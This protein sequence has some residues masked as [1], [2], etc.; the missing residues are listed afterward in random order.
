MSGLP[1]GLMGV[2]ALRTDKQVAILLQ[3]ETKEV[4]KTS[5]SYDSKQW[6]IE[7]PK[8]GVVSVVLR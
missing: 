7:I 1:K 2:A 3:N 6:G 5:I 8:E 4:I